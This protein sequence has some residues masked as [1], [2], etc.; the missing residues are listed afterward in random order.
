MLVAMYVSSSGTVS[1]LNTTVTPIKVNR[2]LFLK[3]NQAIQFI[4]S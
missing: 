3:Q 2:G 4:T 1:G